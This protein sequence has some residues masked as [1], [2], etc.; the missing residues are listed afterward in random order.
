LLDVLEGT[1]D[2][3]PLGASTRAVTPAFRLIAAAKVPLAESGLRAD[4]CERLLEGHSW[5][6]PSLSERREDIA[7]LLRR[8]AREQSKMLGVDVTFTEEALA[9]AEQAPWPGEIRQLRATVI[10]L[11]Q[12]AVAS[13]AGA[14][15]ASSTDS[16]SAKRLPILL[17]SDDLR[18][19]TSERDAVLSRSAVSS[20]PV[21][22]ATA[23][24]EPVK[25]FSRSLTKDDIAKALKRADGNQS[26][27][28][29]QLGIARNTL[30]KKMREFGLA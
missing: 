29:R 6:V 19:H 24:D 27:A 4:L 20:A 26:E 9:F 28:A 1:G 2:P 22:Q 23:Q 15:S 7:V 18:R 14:P 12:A 13:A 25:R 21:A 8:F 11:A 10:V 3:S 16:S 17:R 30:S 5:K